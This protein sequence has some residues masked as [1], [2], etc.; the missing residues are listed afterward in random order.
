MYFWLILEY[1]GQMVSLMPTCILITP[2]PSSKLKEMTFMC[3]LPCTAWVVDHNSGIYHLIPGV[4]FLLDCRLNNP[5][6]SVE[7][8]RKNDGTSFQRVFPRTDRFVKQDG[9][10]FTITGL[11]TKRKF[12]FQCRTTGDAGTP[13]LMKEEVTIERVTGLKQ[14]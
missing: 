6:V 9:Q 8:Y 14:Q 12:I 3:I 7:L 11:A 13:V 10:T 1:K 5:N 2:P 4:P